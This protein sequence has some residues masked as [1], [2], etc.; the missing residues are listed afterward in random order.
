LNTF[1][2]EQQKTP[3]K[4][5]LCQLFCFDR[6]LPIFVFAAFIA[7]FASSFDHGT[8]GEVAKVVYT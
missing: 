5:D 8:F 2:F 4:F 6:F 3:Q 1:L 7:F